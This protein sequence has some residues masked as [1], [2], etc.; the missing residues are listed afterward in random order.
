VIKIAPSSVSMPAQLGQKSSDWALDYFF[1]CITAGR[2][3]K[4]RHRH[5]SRARKAGIKNI[6]AFIEG[7]FAYGYL[8]RAGSAPFLVRIS[9]L[10]PI[11]V[12][13]TLLLR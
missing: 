1:A 12:G 13:T 9:P 6:T 11:S 10:T 2:E 7:D 8:K 5:A 3:L 4:G